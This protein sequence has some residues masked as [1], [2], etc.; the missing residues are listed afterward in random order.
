M[1]WRLA[2]S[3]HRLLT[4][5]LP[6]KQLQQVHHSIPKPTDATDD[7]PPRAIISSA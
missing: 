1:R 5:P 6:P 2:K 4:L 7:R 3:P